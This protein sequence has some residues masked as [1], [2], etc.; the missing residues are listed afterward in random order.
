MAFRPW[1]VDNT[2]SHSPK[3]PHMRRGH[4]HNFWTGPRDGDRKLV[5]HW[6][7]PTFIG[8]KEDSPVVY[9]DVK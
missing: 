8:A 2:G 9:H 6:I 4:W 3:R 5:L 1:V 7:P